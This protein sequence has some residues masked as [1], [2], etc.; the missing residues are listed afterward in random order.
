MIS[1]LLRKNWQ[2]DS[3]LKSIADDFKKFQSKTWSRLILTYIK[4]YVILFMND[5]LLCQGAEMLSPQMSYIKLYRKKY[6][7]SR[8]ILESQSLHLENVVVTR[9]LKICQTSWQFT[10]TK[11]G[12]LIIK[13]ST[14]KYFFMDLNHISIRRSRCGKEL[15]LI[16]LRNLQEM[17]IST[18]D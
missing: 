18:A 9:C 5:A 7:G 3:L 6:H 17:I 13:K 16:F 11:T 4:I 12:L 2:G 14:R 1:K 10:R 15:S 8:T